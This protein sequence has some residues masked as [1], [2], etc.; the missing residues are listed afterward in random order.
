[1]PVWKKKEITKTER[2]VEY[3]TIDVEGNLQELYEI[4]VTETEVCT[5]FHNFIILDFTLNGWMMGRGGRG[6]GYFIS[7]YFCLLHK[8]YCSLFDIR[9]LQLC[10][11]VL[12][13]GVGWGVVWWCGERRVRGEKGNIGDG[14]REIERLRGKKRRVP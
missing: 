1:M 12:C 3:T 4:E 10:C 11:V 5:R 14:D 2:S 6:G 13:G 8:C 7:F 9:L